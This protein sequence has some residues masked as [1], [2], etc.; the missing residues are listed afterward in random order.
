MRECS[1]VEAP[2]PAWEVTRSSSDG[3]QRLQRALDE[4][5]EHGYL[6]H[7]AILLCSKMFPLECKH[8]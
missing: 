5:F 7:L 4:N 6:M 2:W 1:G 8:L 3:V